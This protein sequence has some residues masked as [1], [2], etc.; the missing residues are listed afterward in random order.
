MSLKV[1]LEDR[2]DSL[3]LFLSRD[4]T[5]SKFLSDLL[6]LWDGECLYEWLSLYSSGMDSQE[7]L[8][9]SFLLISSSSSP[10]VSAKL[11]LKQSN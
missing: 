9:S 10:P 5:V 1:L 8:L 2:F 4:A 3:P 7:S 11:L 6:W